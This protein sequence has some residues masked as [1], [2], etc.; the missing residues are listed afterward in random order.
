VLN[1][2]LTIQDLNRL[3]ESINKSDRDTVIVITGNTGEG[4][5]TLGLSLCYEAHKDYDMSKYLAY[6]HEDCIRLLKEGKPG[7][8]IMPDEATN[9]LFSREFSH[10]QQIE[11]IKI[12][13]MIRDKNMSIIMCMPRFWALDSHLRDSRVRYWL[14]IEKRGLAHLFERNKNPFSVDPWARR[15][16][17]KLLAKWA[18]GG[19]IKRAAGYIG[20]VTFPAL[21]K[22][23]E[24]RYREVKLRKRRDAERR[25]QKNTLTELKQ[26]RLL[27]EASYKLVYEHG[28]Q[29]LEAAQILGVQPRTVNNWH[30]DLANERNAIKSREGV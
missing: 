13:D 15:I 21:P 22:D 8:Y 30:K 7:D 29:V 14:Y 1:L 19:G 20:S 11:L 16:N 17:E 25:K 4:K 9:L 5:S 23:V 18:G 3:I 6:S 10:G 2:N 24:I 27:A 28:Y 26:R 12:F